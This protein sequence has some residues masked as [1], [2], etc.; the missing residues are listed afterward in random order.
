MLINYNPDE[1]EYKVEC[2][3]CDFHKKHPK[4]NWAGCTCQGSITQT[5]KKRI[6]TIDDERSE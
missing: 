2:H 1:W 6:I 4:E 5:R 3:P